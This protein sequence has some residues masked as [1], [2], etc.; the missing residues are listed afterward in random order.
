M[1]GARLDILVGCGGFKFKVRR[2][3]K[4][5]M[6]RSGVYAFVM[7]HVVLPKYFLHKHDMTLYANANENQNKLKGP[8]SN[9]FQH[10]SIQSL[11][12]LDVGSAEW[13]SSDA[14]ST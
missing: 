11:S 4:R 3:I 7:R 9:N 10:G 13:H 5:S 6:F 14:K 2:L 8:W 12:V 1:K